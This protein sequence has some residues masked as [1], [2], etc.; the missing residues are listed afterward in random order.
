MNRGTLSAAALLAALAAGVWASL[1]ASALDSTSIAPAG[2]PD[3]G[4]R[5]PDARTLGGKTESQLDVNSAGTAGTSSYA[6]NAGALGGADLGWVRGNATYAASA[7]TASSAA[8]AATAT[9]ATNSSNAS[10]ATTAGNGVSGVSG[11]NLTLSNGTSLALPS[12]G[13]STTTDPCSAS[14]TLQGGK[15]YAQCCAVG[16]TVVTAGGSAVCQ[17]ALACPGGWSAY[18][19]WS[20]TT[21]NSCGGGGCGSTSCS[22]S[23]HSWSNTAREGCSFIPYPGMSTPNGSDWYCNNT[24]GPSTCYANVTARGCI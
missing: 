3:V 20:T 9:T 16:G 8:T 2:L 23:G 17:V 1:P 24:P 19:D 5:T 11:S 4:W 13:G 22:T 18:Q 12:G 21:A 15:T 7:G 6:T 10:Y 14:A